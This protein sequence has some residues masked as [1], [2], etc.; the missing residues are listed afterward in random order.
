[1]AYREHWLIPEQDYPSYAAYLEAAGGNAVERA[2]RMDPTLVLE[3]VHRSGLRGRGGAGFPTGVKWSAVRANPCPTRFVVCNAAEGE[4]GTFK[5]RFLLGRNPY[6]TL[7]GM[8][9]CAHAIGAKAGFIAIKA[10][11]ARPLARL[12]A[13]LAEMAG[14]MGG[15][16]ITIV[17]GPDEYLFGEETAMLSVIDGEGPL[18]RPPESPAYEVGLRATAGSPNPAVCNNAETFAHVPSVIR[19]GAASFRNVGTSDTSGTILFTLSGDLQ[20]PGVYE[21]PAGTSLRHLFYEVGGGPPPGRTFKAALPGVSAAP[22]LPERFDIPADFGSLRLVGSGLGSAGFILFDDQT[23]MPRVAQAVARFLY[24]E[25]CNQCSACKEGLR[26]AS[27]ALDEIFDPAK[28]TPDD[29]ERALFGAWRAP[30]GNRCYLPVQGATVIPSLMQRFRAEID[31]QVSH[32]TGAPPAYVLPKLADFDEASRTFTVD[33]MQRL[34][35]PNWT[36]AEPPQPPRPPSAPSSAPRGHTAVRLHPDLRAALADLGGG[37]DG[38]LDLD[39]QVNE[40]LHD[41]LKSQKRKKKRSKK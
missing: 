10:S 25:S 32:P 19:A 14:T 13:A 38:D 16:S 37:G 24:V 8:L 26:T 7:E 41:W 27:R 33:S 29:P 31:A 2:R 3:Q 34:K 11:F 12:R 5:D 15:V 18:P 20:R 40:A 36:Y 23:S 39:R 21:L 4:P 35:L 6:S 9:I 30:Q 22:I 17:E 28:A 1:M